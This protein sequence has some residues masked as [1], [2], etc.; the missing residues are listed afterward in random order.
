MRKF[1]QRLV[2]KQEGAAMVEYALLIAGVALIGAASVST[3]GHK[4]NDMIAMTAGVLPGAH[5]DD[6]NP[7][8]SGKIIETFGAPNAGSTT[9]TAIALDIA[10]IVGNSG[11][12]R[13]DL[14]LGN[15]DGTTPSTLVLEPK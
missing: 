6:N 3:F 15:S 5:F 8:A 11:K 2:R 10:T 13:L 1:F 12:D 9:G 14:N 7:I 4:T